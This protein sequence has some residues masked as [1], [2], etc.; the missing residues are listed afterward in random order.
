MPLIAPESIYGLNDRP[1]KELCHWFLNSK[2]WAIL[3]IVLRPDKMSTQNQQDEIPGEIK[4]F[5]S[6]TRFSNQNAPFI[7]SL[8]RLLAG[9]LVQNHESN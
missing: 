1:S 7:P 5:P 9:F 3:E 2:K 4:P 6:M 8:R